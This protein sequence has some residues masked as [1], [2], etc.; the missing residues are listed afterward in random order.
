MKYHIILVQKYISRIRFKVKYTEFLYFNR[1]I[2][3][4]SRVFA[5]SP[6]DQGSNPRLSHTKN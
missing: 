5:K 6:G 4:T 1:G 3:L 2:G